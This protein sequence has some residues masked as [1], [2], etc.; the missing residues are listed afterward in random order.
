MKAI[1]LHR[2]TGL[3][4]PRVTFSTRW[5]GH[6]V[7]DIQWK[8]QENTKHNLMLH[9][10]EGKPHRFQLDT[11]GK[12]TTIPNKLP[13]SYQSKCRNNKQQTSGQKTVKPGKLLQM[14]T[15]RGHRTYTDAGLGGSRQQVPCKHLMFRTVG[16]T[17]IFRRGAHASNPCMLGGW[18]K[19]ITS[20]VPCRAT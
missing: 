2:E 1:G 8:S 10:S 11:G 6:W 13:V 19:K 16:K 14:E 3:Y 4:L 9:S 7:M 17:W 18:G 12:P 5:K 20:M 15:S